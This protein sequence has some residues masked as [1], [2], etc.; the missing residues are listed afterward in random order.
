M[1]S[2][3]DQPLRLFAID[4]ATG[5]ERLIHEYPPDGR[6]YTE[7]FLNTARLYPSRDGKSLLS[8]RW[9]VR[10]SIWMLEGVEPPQSFWRR[11][12]R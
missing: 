7:L 4:V 6:R 5:V 2:D 9:S 12:L 1:E 8:S 3:V 10:S 11:L